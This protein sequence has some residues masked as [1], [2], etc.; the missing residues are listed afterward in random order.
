MIEVALRRVL[1]HSFPRYLIIGGLSFAVDFGALYV[2]HG[3]LHIWLPVATTLAFLLAFVVNFG[4]NRVW[5]FE[6]EGHVGRQLVL[7]LLLVALNTVLTVVVVSGLAALG[8]QYLIAKTVATA[9]LTVLNYLA[10]R[11][12]VFVGAR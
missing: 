9:A 6:S 1:S 2:A 7:Y 10:Y 12:W 8:V 11:K 5:A 4:L 3:L